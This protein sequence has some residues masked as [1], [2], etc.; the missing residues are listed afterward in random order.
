MKKNTTFKSVHENLV[1]D[2][3]NTVVTKHTVYYTANSDSN[4]QGCA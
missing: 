3:P 1:G 2:H 4:F